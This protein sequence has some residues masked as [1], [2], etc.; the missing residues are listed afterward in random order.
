VQHFQQQASLPG[1]GAIGEPTW[2]APAGASAARLE[3]LAWL[4]P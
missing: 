2:L 3:S 4:L 1:T